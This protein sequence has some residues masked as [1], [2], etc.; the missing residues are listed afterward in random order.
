MHRAVWRHKV[1]VLNVPRGRDVGLDPH[2]FGLF[3]NTLEGFRVMLVLPRTDPRWVLY[4]Y[5]GLYLDLYTCIREAGLTHK[6][7]VVL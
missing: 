4:G 6:L 3:Y 2:L 5:V 1:P 7:V